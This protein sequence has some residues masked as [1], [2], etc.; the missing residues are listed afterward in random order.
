V[1]CLSK[2]T[3]LLRPGKD[4]LTMEDYQKN[5]E[6]MH[7][8]MTTSMGY[9][10]NSFQVAMFPAGCRF[11]RPV[12]EAVPDPPIG[13]GAIVFITWD[14]IHD[15]QQIELFEKRFNFYLIFFPLK[16]FK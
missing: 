2:L 12:T 4:V 3:A 15:H 5:W 14:T 1:K 11:R 13:T 8:Q 16:N 6:L 7:R 10:A 9:S